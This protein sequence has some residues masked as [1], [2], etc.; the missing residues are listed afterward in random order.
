VCKN[1]KP[2]SQFSILPI[3]DE[4]VCTEDPSIGEISRLLRERFGHDL[5]IDGDLIETVTGGLTL[6]VRGNGVPPK[7]LPQVSDGV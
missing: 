4:S 7:D 2:H 6:T 1:T 5:H 3:L